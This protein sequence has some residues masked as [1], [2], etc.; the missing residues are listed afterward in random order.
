MS[1]TILV[2][3]LGFVLLIAL[4]FLGMPIY[5]SMLVV[6][7]GGN[8]TLAFLNPD[9]VN[10][11]IGVLSYFF[12]FKTL[13][14]NFL[15]NL[16]LMVL[17]IFIFLS[18]FFEET[19]MSARVFAGINYFIGRVKSGLGIATI[20]SAG[21]I[22]A[23]S[24]SS[25]AT[26]SAI[27][28]A[29]Y[30]ELKKYNYN[31]RLISGIVASAGTLGTLIPPSFVLIIY[32][33]L[34]E[35]SILEM[36][37]A[38]FIPAG[39]AI[40][41]FSTLTHF[42]VTKELKASKQTEQDEQNKNEASSSVSSWTEKFSFNKNTRIALKGILPTFL[43]FL[44]IFLGL[45]QGW[46]SLVEVAC[47]ASFLVFI[48]SLIT[49]KLNLKKLYSIFL[50][51]ANYSAMLYMILFGAEILKSFFSRS[52]LPFFFVDQLTAL[53]NWL[54]FSWGLSW[55]PWL[56]LLGVLLFLIILG[57]FLESLTI[58]LIFV[59]FFWPLLVELNGGENIAP[60]LSYFNLSNDE[61]KIWFGIL[62]LIIVEVGLITP[63]M[64]LNLFI[65]KKV[66]P[67]LSLAEIYL[68]VL[69]YIMLEI[70]RINIILFFPF[71]LF[72]L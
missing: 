15:S 29:S 24:S 61:L 48:Y 1:L 7:I 71:I 51:T 59:P 46:F 26:T 14:W 47:L 31:D 20:F 45:F 9:I 63:P 37:K 49:K 36:F 33:V 32:A 57:C 68:G 22:G 60:H 19:G 53:I 5:L 2:G 72:L 62:M 18:F 52:N 27:G 43:L 55:S 4:I 58:I 16:N 64:G 8:L 40:V 21:L 3:V 10:S 11:N 30:Q 67:D 42:L 25:L 12:Q 35:T 65:L 41:F 66:V 34:V 69:P 54:D 50:R 39:L 23:I 38:A 6:G 13:L 56:V 70:V 28:A 44:L 17:P